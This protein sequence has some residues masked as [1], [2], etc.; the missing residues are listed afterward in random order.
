MSCSNKN[1]TDFWHLTIE[2]TEK[3]PTSSNFEIALQDASITKDKEHRSLRITKYVDNNRITYALNNYG[4][5]SISYTYESETKEAYPTYNKISK[6]KVSLQSIDD[7]FKEYSLIYIETIYHD[8]NFIENKQIQGN[9]QIVN[10]NDVIY[11]NVPYLQ[12]A[13]QAFALLLNE[14]QKEYK[15]EY[16]NTNF[17]PVIEYLNKQ[18]IPKYENNVSAFLEYHSKERI[19]AKGYRLTTIITLNKDNNTLQ[20]KEYCHEQAAY[21]FNYTTS[22]QARSIENLYD[23]ILNDPTIAYAIYINDNSLYLYTQTMSDQDIYNDILN[24]NGTNASLHLSKK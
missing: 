9:I 2:A 12:E 18:S 6:H 22:L 10:K 14:F 13:V 23:M 8:Q 17:I 4:T 3:N 11:D 16:K 5:K 24:N 7:A 21:T 15:I 20:F 1:N 19:N